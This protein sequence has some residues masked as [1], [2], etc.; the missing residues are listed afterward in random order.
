MKMAVDSDVK[1]I[2]DDHEKRIA[3]L[4]SL[5]AKPRKA[6]VPKNKRRLTE[7]MIEFRKKG[8]FAQP[9][10]AEETHA[11]LQQS[12]HCDP[13]RVAVALFRL[14]KRRQLR[15]ATKVVNKKEYQAYVW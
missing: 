12:Y 2:L 6:S 9:K 8:F 4:E 14:S 5:V 3:Y 13:N 7:H 1:K 15:R 11:K 10:T